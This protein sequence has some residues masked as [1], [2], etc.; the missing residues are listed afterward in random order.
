VPLLCSLGWGRLQLE[1]ANQVD[2]RRPQVQVVQRRPQINHVS[3]LAAPRVQAAEHV[4]LKESWVGG[5]HGPEAGQQRSREAGPDAEEGNVT[6]RHW[7][8]TG[9]GLL[10]FALRGLGHA[11]GLR[12]LT[13]SGILLAAVACVWLARSARVE[14]RADTIDHTSGNLLDAEL[15]AAKMTFGARMP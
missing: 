2:G 1:D 9:A 5:R 15:S 10:G 7:L 6:P 14:N 13:V 12:W 3:L 8:L 11:L 4:V